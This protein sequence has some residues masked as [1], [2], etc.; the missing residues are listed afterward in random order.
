M[1]CRCRSYVCIQFKLSTGLYFWIASNASCRG[2][3]SDITY[4][5]IDVIV[6]GFLF[7]IL[8]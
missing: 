7:T 8:F 5:V 1:L 3:A 4:V 2:L 6:F